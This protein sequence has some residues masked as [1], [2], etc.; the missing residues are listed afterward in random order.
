MVAED[1]V[2]LVFSQAILTLHTLYRNF[3]STKAHTYPLPYKLAQSRL[4]RASAWLQL[5]T[6]RPCARLD[7]RVLDLLSVPCM[8]SSYT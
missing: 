7:F 8:I 5:N 3:D 1:L 6:V 4:L 2:L